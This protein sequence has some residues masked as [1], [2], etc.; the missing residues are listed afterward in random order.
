MGEDA[1]A[2]HATGLPEYG[3]V[4]KV[5]MHPQAQRASSG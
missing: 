3:D 4:T 5:W 1:H 2:T